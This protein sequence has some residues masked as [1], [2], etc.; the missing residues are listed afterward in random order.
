MGKKGKTSASKASHARSRRQS[1]GG[2]KGGAA[3]HTV[4][5]L[6]TSISSFAISSRLLASFPQASPK[7]RA[8]SKAKKMQTGNFHLYKESM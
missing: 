4:P 5:N 1:W 8:C 3:F 6:P 7:W 2:E